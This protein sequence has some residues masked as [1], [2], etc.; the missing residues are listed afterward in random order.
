MFSTTV[1]APATFKEELL[2]PRE[3]LIKAVWSN[4]LL[5]LVGVGQLVSGCLY[6]HS[7]KQ[8]A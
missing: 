2:V 8:H 1:G 4:I 7:S 6:E 3:T 5:C